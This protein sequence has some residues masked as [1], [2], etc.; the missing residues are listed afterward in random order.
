M[1]DIPTAAGNRKPLDFLRQRPPPS[2]PKLRVFHAASGGDW[3]KSGHFHICIMGSAIWP[4]F[5]S[6]QI[7]HDIDLPRKQYLLSL[8]HHWLQSPETSPNSALQSKQ[9]G[10][11]SQIPS[12]QHRRTCPYFVCFNFQDRTRVTSEITP[13]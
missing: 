3:L 1:R 2:P 10:M 9:K 7:R 5:N 4:P 12:N 11:P 13:F 6:H 8:D